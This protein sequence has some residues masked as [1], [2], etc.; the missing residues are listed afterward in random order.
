MAGG[1]RVAVRD[2]HERARLGRALLADRGLDEARE[3]V[4]GENRE[5]DEDE[6]EQAAAENGDGHPDIAACPERL[7][8]FV[9]LNDGKG[10]FGPGIQFQ[11]PQA[12]PYSMIAAD[13]NGDGHPDVIV[14]YVGAPGVIYY[15]DGTGK[16]FDPH[17]FGD[18]QGAI[19]GMAAG[20]INGDGRLDLVAARSDAPSFLLFNRGSK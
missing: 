9:Y 13:L 6:R 11:K 17:S 1:K 10:N 20:D 19:Y 12:Q 7:G 8:C 2:R 15:N 14:G 3:P 18:G 5:R 4:G 16:K